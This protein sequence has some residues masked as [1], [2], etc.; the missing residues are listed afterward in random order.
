M[1]RQ[2]LKVEGHMMFFRVGHRVLFHSER[3]VLFRSFKER[4]VLFCSFFEF[5]ATYAT[6]K[7]VPFFP[8]EGK[9]TQKMQ[10]SFAKNVKERNERKR[11]QITQCSFAKNVKESKGTRESF[12]LLQKNAER[13]VLFSIYIYRY[14]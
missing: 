13:S 3:S 12:V 9:I 4:N 10:R 14:I 2:K 8:K 6:Q 11:T 7:N 1:K 5:L